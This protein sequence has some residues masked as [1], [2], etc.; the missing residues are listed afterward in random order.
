MVS[1]AG[2]SGAT[3]NTPDILANV[4]MVG[5]RTIFGI[6]SIAFLSLSAY[7]RDSS[8][9]PPCDDVLG[10]AVMHEDRSLTIFMD[11]AVYPLNPP[12]LTL[13][14]GTQAYSW[15]LHRLGEMHPG[16]RSQLIWYVAMVH[17]NTDRSI[18]V[19][20][21]GSSDGGTDFWPS[22]EVLRP[23]KS[24]YDNILNSVG[25]LEPEQYKGIRYTL[26]T[27]SCAKRFLK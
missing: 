24:K 8:F 26:P 13:Q 6:I 23:G 14:P 15:Y 21:F 17:M 10:Y 19:E 7:A 12:P 18:D 27:A 9:V 11:P 22:S 1:T 16:E 3:S 4:Q 25:G 20:W 2:I 5:V